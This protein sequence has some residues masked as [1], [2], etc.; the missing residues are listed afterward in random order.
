[1]RQQTNELKRYIRE[2]FNEFNALEQDIN[3]FRPIFNSL[4]DVLKK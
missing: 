1:M 4:L 3:K 2:I